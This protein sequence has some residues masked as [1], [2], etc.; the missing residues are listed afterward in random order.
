MNDLTVMEAGEAVKANATVTCPE[1]IDDSCAY[2][3]NERTLDFESLGNY[4]RWPKCENCG[5]YLVVEW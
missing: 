5:H 1:P 4:V 2:Q 3:Y